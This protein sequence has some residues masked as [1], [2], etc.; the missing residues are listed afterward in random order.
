M[1]WPAPLA[2]WFDLT[3]P[4]SWL[5]ASR[6]MDI[7]QAADLTVVWKPLFQS[8]PPTKREHSAS[9]QEAA[10]LR[11][12]WIWEDV[13]RAA[14]RYGLRFRM[15]RVY[16]ADTKR[17]MRVAV[18]ALDEGW[19]EDFVRAAGHAAFADDRDLGDAEQIRALIRACGQD[20]K[21]VEAA[22]DAPDCDAK[23]EAYNAAAAEKRVFGA[24]MFVVHEER[25]WGNDR[26][27]Q[28]A[29]YAVG[30]NAVLLD[31]DDCLE[32]IHFAFRNVISEPDKQLEPYGFRRLHHQILY[33]C[34]KHAPLRGRELCE[35]LGLSKQAL[36]GPLTQ[37]RGQGMIELVPDPEDGRARIIQLTTAGLAFEDAMSGAQRE[38]FRRVAREETPQTQLAF[39]RMLAAL[40]EGR[41]AR[42]TL[43]RLSESTS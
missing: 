1:S 10:G 11:D 38:L 8:L 30:P 39:L 34:R 16:P 42:S 33:M 23:V 25:F 36:H 5:A 22:I 32:R 24:P 41:D 7:A 35:V 20:P 37:L 26:L 28:A 40:G 6:V 13:Q 3:S 17:A 4:Y 12:A 19:G 43:Q 18:V 31:A 15:P 9:E 29:A 27:S 21:R 2:F 14:L